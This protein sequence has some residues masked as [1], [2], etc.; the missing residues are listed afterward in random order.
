MRKISILLALCCALALPV[1]CASADMYPRNAAVGIVS[2]RDGETDVFT[3]RENVNIYDVHITPDTQINLSHPL[4]P[5]EVVY[6]VFEETIEPGD[7]WLFAEVSAARIADVSFDMQIDR[8]PFDPDGLRAKMGN[9]LINELTAVFPEG[10]DMKA[11]TGSFIHAEVEPVP[12]VAPSKLIQVTSFEEM[13]FLSGDILE[14]TEDGFVIR[15]TLVG[16]SG[17]VRVRMSEETMCVH[18]L[19]P[20]MTVEV[21]YVGEESPEEADALTVWVAYG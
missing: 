11:L 5:G 9:P 19:S 15:R 17:D 20:G 14:M 13:N 1:A 4:A 3:L 18:E 12:G 21:M 10:T 16:T 6:V 8:E 2:M 7:A